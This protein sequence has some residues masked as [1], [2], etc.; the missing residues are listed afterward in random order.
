MNKY[1]SKIFISNAIINLIKS[2][3]LSFISSF[4]NSLNVKLMNL[5]LDDFLILFFEFARL[6]FFVF[7]LCALKFMRRRAT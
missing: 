6:D 2:F 3:K 4:T 7:I 1:K 5:G